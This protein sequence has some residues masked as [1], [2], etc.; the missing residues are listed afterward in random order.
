M[1]APS[2]RDQLIEAA[3]VLFAERGIDGVS[4]REI[5]AAAGVRNASALQYHFGGRAGLLQ[6]ILAKHKPAV[7]ARRHALLDAHDRTD[8]GDLRVLAGALVRPLAECLR[9][10]GGP[11]YVRVLA[12]LV[13]RP[14]PAID[15]AAMED[16]S[17][18]LTRWRGEVEPLLAP[19]AAVLHRRFVAIR[20]TLAEL[21]RRPWDR[22]VGGD[23]LFLADLTDLVTGV[24]AAPVSPETDRLVARR[25]A[26]RLARQ[27]A[28]QRSSERSPAPADGAEI[29]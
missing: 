28:A 21:A 1:I 27:R 29:D 15:R 25:Q 14:Q 11:G 22:A 8:G 7:E 6:A 16:P 4:L 23:A 13:N 3:E 9:D 12:D 5:T 26:R 18:S 2:A 20:F 10:P 24:L 19:G 17:D